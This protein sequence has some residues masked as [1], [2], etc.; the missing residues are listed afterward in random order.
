MKV[1]A[2]N[3]NKQVEKNQKTTYQKYTQ[4]YNKF[5]KLQKYILILTKACT[6]DF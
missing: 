5:T 4:H 3:N 6:L 1:K 2:G